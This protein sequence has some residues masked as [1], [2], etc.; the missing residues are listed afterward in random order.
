MK[1]LAYITDYCK[2]TARKFNQLDQIAK[3]AEK[4]EEDQSIQSWDSFLP[5]PYIKKNL[6]R[7]YR[8]VCSKYPINDDYTIIVFI[9]CYA[10]GGDGT[11]EKFINNPSI[12]DKLRPSEEDIIS[13]IKQREERNHSS[14]PSLPDPN[15]IEFN[16]LHDSIKIGSHS[17]FI[18]Y[19]S[20]D[21]VEA[22]KSTSVFEKLTRIYDLILNDIIPSTDYNKCTSK[23]INGICLLYKYF[24]E[25]NCI[26][27]ITIILPHEQSKIDKY[28]EQY[29]DIINQRFNSLEFILKNSRRSY[30]AY[31]LADED[32]WRLIE[33]NE[34]GNISLSPEESAILENILSKSKTKLFPLF[35]NGRPGSG[36]STI[37]QYLFASYLVLYLKTDIK[38]RLKNPPLYLTYSDSLLD[39]AQSIVKTILKC[40][41]H[42]SQQNFDLREFDQIKFHCFG[43][44]HKFLLKILPDAICERFDIRKKVDFPKFKRMWDDY[45]KSHP[46]SEVR[47]LAPELV[48]HVLRSYIKG[49]RYDELAEFTLESFKELPSRQRSVQEKTFEIIYNKS[50]IRW[51]RPLCEKEGYWDDQDLVYTVLNNIELD[52]LAQYPAIFCDEAQDFSK[53]ELDLILKLNLYS[54]RSLLPEQLRYVPFVFAGD[55]FQTLNPTGFDFDSLQAN[56]HEKIVSGLDKNSKANLEFNYQELSYNYRSSRF[57]VG[58]C[59]LIQLL[60]GILFDQK[61]LIPQKTWFDSSASMPIIFNLKN[62]LCEQKLKEQT[63]LVIILPC[64]EGEED[65]FVKN[66]DF[67]SKLKEQDTQLGRNF[68]SPMRAKGLEFSR[69]VLYK[70]GSICKKRYPNFLEPLVTKKPHSI[71][72][73]QAL[74]LKYFINSLYVAA[75]RAKKMLI[76]VDDDEGIDFLWKNRQIKSLDKLILDY[77]NASKYGWN[78]DLINYVQEG[79]ENIWSQDRDDPESLA[80][81]F[82]QS[83]FAKRDPYELRLAEANYY[84]CQKEYDAKLCRADRYVIEKKFRKAGELYLELHKE[85]KALENF[86]KAEEF[87]LIAKIQEFENTPEQRAA[88]FELGNKSKE[89][90][91]HFLEFLLEQIK[92]P[93]KTK[94]VTDRLW[95]KFLNRCIDVGLDLP[96]SNKKIYSLLRELESNGLAPTDISKYANLAYH[97]E[98][99]KH[100][101]ELWDNSPVQQDTKQYFKA[102]SVTEDFPN[103]LIWLDKLRDHDSII[104][105]YLKN[106]HLDISDNHLNI[107]FNSIYQSNCQDVLCEFVEKF[108]KIQYLFKVFQ[109]FKKL[110]HNAYM[111]KVA[112]IL[113]PKLVNEERW[114]DIVKI[115][116][117]ISI[118]QTVYN[119]LISILAYATACSNNLEH[120]SIEHKDAIGRLLRKTF[121]ECQWINKVP[122]RIAGAA[123]EKAYNIKDVLL[124]YEQ[125]WK[126]EK[127]KC[128]YEDKLYAIQRWVCFKLNYADLLD[129]KN[130][131]I[132]AKDHRLEAEKVC[133]RYLTI[134]I[135]NIP[136]HPDISS[137]KNIETT[138]LSRLSDVSMDKRK[139]I[140]QLYN[141]GHSVDKLVGIFD[142]EAD[143]IEL[144]LKE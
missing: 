116:R 29:S 75:S 113:I 68:L 28:I 42:F 8:L 64:Q 49:M 144:I 142:L 4:I 121:I 125:V 20:K 24:N 119:E 94:F 70:F 135:N 131:E 58:F 38:E 23:D 16:F 128:S 22:I 48:W 50:W 106:N 76:I 81:E 122:M 21:W 97:A 9:A 57:I 54:R 117:N 14:L 35:I 118:N 123:L 26:F 10:R 109:H 141:L 67:L 86:W 129:K 91:E 96:K 72:M 33:K 31:T 100:A 132:K 62:P 52:T 61:A 5:T 56:F 98:E 105:E 19:E 99:Y 112:K 95:T 41:V 102:R 15:H 30:P 32:I 7:S 88:Y 53:L 114:N 108:P 84:R 77:K 130:F 44:F 115:L 66:D 138:H 45:R 136:Q 36:K 51:Y 93:S 126:K 55:P 39:S 134:D 25:Y 124:F 120:A 78:T 34:T 46:N 43:I 2:Q 71:N 65:E 90:T 1:Y 79:T 17:E 12:C 82:H 74:P 60:R 80:K 107:I 47:E 73:D 87:K 40:N 137:V 3:L 6:G 127:I 37:L 13:S 27:L 139:A 143:I 85:E 89:E 83:G 140:K 69:V 59:N 133:N 101:I 103:N 63:E 92:G 110:D 18:I 11:Y 104:K 111:I